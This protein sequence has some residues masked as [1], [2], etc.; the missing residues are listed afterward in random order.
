M[1][2]GLCVWLV[3]LFICLFRCGFVYFVV[4]LM[5]CG[6]IGRFVVW[7][8]ICE[9]WL[10]GSLFGL[11]A[12]CGVHCFLGVFVCLFCVPV[13]FLSVVGLFVTWLVGWLTYLFFGLLVSYSAFLSGGR[14]LLV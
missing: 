9:L 11:S 13:L 2:L 5:V 3:C 10:F 1:C 14:V 7:L 6:L 4:S 8:F 12:G